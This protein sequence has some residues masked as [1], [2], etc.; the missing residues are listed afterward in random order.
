[1]DLNS[2][3][4]KQSDTPKVQFIPEPISRNDNVFGIP[5]FFWELFQLFGTE[6][7]LQSGD[8][9]SFHETV[10]KY[11]Q[12]RKDDASEFA[13]YLPEIF[14]FDPP[15]KTSTDPLKFQPVQNRYDRLSI[16][17]WLHTCSAF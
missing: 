8:R 12:S 3:S 14:Q 16:R 17:A 10:E 15:G 4:K 2:F 1:M 11:L 9:K 6:D 7:N 13:K 5:H